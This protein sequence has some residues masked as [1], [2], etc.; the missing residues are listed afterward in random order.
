MEVVGSIVVL[1]V[2]LCVDVMVTMLTAV[3]VVAVIVEIFE[4]ASIETVE[5][6]VKIGEVAII[7]LVD[8]IKELIAEVDEIVEVESVSVGKE[9]GTLVDDT[10]SGVIIS[11]KL[12]DK[13]R[14]VL[15][16]KV[17]VGRV[18]VVALAVFK[19]VIKIVGA[20]DDRVVVE[21]IIEET[22]E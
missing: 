20:K 6:V 3:V 9:S 7:V 11:V 1:E 19:K 8:V 2:I 16:A 21:L 13:D 14:P 12:V 4:D 10:D 22:A 18:V 5:L 17:A 15:L